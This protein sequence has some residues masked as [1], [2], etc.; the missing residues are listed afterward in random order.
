MLSRNEDIWDM[1]NIVHKVKR[2]LCICWINIF[3]PFFQ[4]SYK[5][6]KLTRIKQK[7]KWHNTNV[8]KLTQHLC[9]EPYV[10]VWNIFLNWSFSSFFCFHLWSVC[11]WP[12]FVRLFLYLTIWWNIKHEMT[13]YMVSIHL[14][15]YVFTWL[16]K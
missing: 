8:S 5:K 9:G 2:N 4:R 6:T 12:L 16:K 13:H 3:F 14:W 10:N 1:Y 11:M 7:N 15:W